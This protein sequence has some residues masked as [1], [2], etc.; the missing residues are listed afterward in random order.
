MKP[1]KA[2][3]LIFAF[4]TLFLFLPIFLMAQG[5]KGN[6]D[7]SQST[8]KELILKD[9]LGADSLSTTTDSIAKD[10]LSIDSIKPKKKEPINAPVLFFHSLL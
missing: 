6:S 5:R 1:L 4:V 2:K 9:S 7:I 10:S 8:S 3:F